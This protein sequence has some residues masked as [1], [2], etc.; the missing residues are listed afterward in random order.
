VG[1]LI[2][3]YTTD[4]RLL[5]APQ[6]ANFQAFAFTFEGLPIAASVE[7]LDVQIGA[8]QRD[9]RHVYI[10]ARFYNPQAGEVVVTSSDVWMVFGFVPNS[11][12]GSHQ[13]P[14]EWEGMTLASGQSLDVMITFN[15][16]GRD[17]YAYLHIAGRE[18]G[19][20]LID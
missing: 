13:A 17:P 3:R 18:F 4:A 20:N 14:L 2:S 6:A 11:A 1:F 10:E 8:I 19:I 5:V 12:S 7:Y 9:S 15:W 16:N